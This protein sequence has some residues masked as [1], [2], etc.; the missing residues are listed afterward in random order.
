MFIY[1]SEFFLY[2]LFIKYLLTRRERMVIEKEV[3]MYIY[4]FANITESRYKVDRLYSSSSG[5]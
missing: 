3:K 1:S 4:Q 2:D 5:G